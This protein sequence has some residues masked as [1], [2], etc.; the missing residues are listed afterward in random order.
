MSPS[1]SA[2]GTRPHG[3]QLGMAGGAVVASLIWYNVLLIVFYLFKGTPQQAQ[4]FLAEG[5]YADS[6]R[7]GMSGFDAWVMGDFLGAGFYHM[8]LLPALAA[9][10]GLIGGALGEGLARLRS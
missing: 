4:V 1:Q 9:I 6:A 10:L 8:L 3:L 5:N 7:S 2:S